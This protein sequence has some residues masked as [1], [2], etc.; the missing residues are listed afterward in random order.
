MLRFCA[1]AAFACVAAAVSISC[2]AVSRARCN[3]SIWDFAAPAA[4]C[5]L[6]LRVLD[7][8]QER[9]LDLPSLGMTDRA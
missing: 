3:S 8:A 5:R 9:G 6:A 1:A 7:V 2:A 4:Q